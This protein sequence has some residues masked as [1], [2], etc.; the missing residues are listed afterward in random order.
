MIS[1]RMEAAILAGAAIL[2][3]LMAPRAATAQQPVRGYI[4]ARW[5]SG[6]VL[7]TGGHHACGC[8][9]VCPGCSC[10]LPTEYRSF[11]PVAV[12]GASRERVGRS[13]YTGDVAAPTAL[14]PRSPVAPR[15]A[16]PLGPAAPRE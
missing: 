1:V 10:L 16:M 9:V 4:D 15:P 6:Y 11:A 2:A 5:N 13:W 7:R 8:F 12:Q 14:L 3:S